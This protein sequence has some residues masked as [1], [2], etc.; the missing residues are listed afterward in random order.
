[1]LP[2]PFSSAIIDRVS[3]KSFAYRAK[4]FAAVIPFFVCVKEIA[5]SL[6]SSQ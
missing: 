5:S 2:F 6:R 1:M 3:E 4:F